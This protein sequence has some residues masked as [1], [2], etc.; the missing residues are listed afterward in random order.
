MTSR[1]NKTDHV[2]ELWSGR[3]LQGAGLEIVHELGEG[4]AHTE[5]E[6][7]DLAPR[8]VHL[9]PKDGRITVKSATRTLP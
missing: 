8:H 7:A 1:I 5:V 9:Q 2:R 6:D 3:V 4:L